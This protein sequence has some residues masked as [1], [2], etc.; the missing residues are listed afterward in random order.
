MACGLVRIARP[1]LDAWTSDSKHVLHPTVFDTFDGISNHPLILG[2]SP[3]VAK[4]TDGK[5]WFLNSDGVSIIDPHT[6]SRNTLPPP[7]HVEQVVA[8][9]KPYDARTGLRLPP[10]V[11]DLQIDYTALSLVAPEKNRF[12]VML[13]GRDRDWQ[14]VGTRRQAFYTDLGP[15]EYRFR[16]V[17]SNNDGVWNEAGA[18]LD[19]SIAPAYYQTRWFQAAMA[20]SFAALLWAAYQLRVAQLA[21]QFN[22]TLDARVSE[23]TRIARDLHDTLLQS[24]HGALLRFQAAA[25]V[26]AARPDEARVRLERALDQ[27]EAAIVEGRNAVQGLRASATTVNDLASGIAA[28]GAELTSDP[29][30]PHVPAIDVKV[31][32]ESRD[33]NPVVREE[34]FRIAGEALRNAVKHAQARRITITIY[35]EPRQLRL[36]IRDDGKGLDPETMARQQKP[37]H[38]GLRG[39]AE[40]AS[41]VNGQLEVR[42]AIGAGTEIELRVPGRIAYR[43]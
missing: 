31:D 19:F 43:A 15:G 22:R 28:I 17:A 37:G 32:R 23:R 8:D 10:L 34:A 3:M 25:N 6:L 29:S 7:V 12:R 26:L 1:E 5:L 40:R 35:Y 39:M 38:F 20:F 24:F 30:A 36:V 13:E 2:L 41:I 33:L 16:V 27:A 14:N 42:G 18:S 11:R 4:S 9:R 21:R